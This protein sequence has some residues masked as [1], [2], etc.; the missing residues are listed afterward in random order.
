MLLTCPTG[1][2][3]NDQA[4]LKSLTLESRTTASIPLLHVECH[5]DK[6]EGLEFEN[7]SLLTWSDLSAALVELNRATGLNLLAV[8]SACYGAYFLS[9]LS[10]VEPTPCYAMF[11][12]TEEIDPAEILQ[13]FRDF[14]RVLFESGDAGAAVGGALHGKDSSGQWLA[15]RADRLAE[16][17]SVFRAS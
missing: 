10:S 8:F 2:P 7:G 11:A 5:G 12:P 9:R 17:I 3:E 6:H 15:Q 13:T 4:L 16:A 1:T 14:Y